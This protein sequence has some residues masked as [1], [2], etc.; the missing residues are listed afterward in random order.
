MTEM[1]TVGAG[2]RV[3]VDRVAGSPSRRDALP[4]VA[5]R[6]VRFDRALDG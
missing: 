5:W 2:E 4:V 3:V 1:A 6:Y